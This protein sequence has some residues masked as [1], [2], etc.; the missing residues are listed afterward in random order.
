MG[1]PTA[2]VGDGDWVGAGDDELGGG[3]ELVGAGAVLY[4][5]LGC[6]VRCGAGCLSLAFLVWLGGAWVVGPSTTGGTAAGEVV[7]R[8]TFAAWLLALRDVLECVTGTGGV[9]PLG[10]PRSTSTSR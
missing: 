10:V 7:D 3:A 5:V 6:C 9:P 2:P 8:T 4:A 1:V